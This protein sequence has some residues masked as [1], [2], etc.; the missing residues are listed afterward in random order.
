MLRTT[1]L[2]SRAGGDKQEGRRGREE[3]E[4]AAVY[5]LV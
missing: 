4:A 1:G 5:T 3:Q 2:G